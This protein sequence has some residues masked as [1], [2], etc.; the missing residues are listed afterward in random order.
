MCTFTTAFL[1][2][3]IFILFFCIQSC[4]SH[5]LEHCHA[6][7]LS[8]LQGAVLAQRRTEP[9]IQSDSW[10][11]VALEKRKLNPIAFSQKFP[12]PPKPH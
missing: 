5:T 6:G 11:V 4:V 1:F 3:F 2:Y 7:N 10:H 8:G 9:T 12:S